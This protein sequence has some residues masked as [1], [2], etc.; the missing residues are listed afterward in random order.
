MPYARLPRRVLPDELALQT[1]R[2]YA[3][4]EFAAVMLQ[5]VVRSDPQI[6]DLHA[7]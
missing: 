4:T 6:P 1:R 5:A 2:L 3:L 7:D